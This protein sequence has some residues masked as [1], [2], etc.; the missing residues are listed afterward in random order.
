MHSYQQLQQPQSRA[1]M[2]AFRL[3]ANV[4]P[5]Q[6]GTGTHNGSTLPKVQLQHRLVHHDRVEGTD[7]T[8]VAADNDNDEDEDEVDGNENDDDNSGRSPNAGL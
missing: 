5:A 1:L 3:Y 7:T 8:T 2:A 4:S 6:E